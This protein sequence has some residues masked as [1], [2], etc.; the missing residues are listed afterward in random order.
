MSAAVG[1]NFMLIDVVGVDL[2]HIADLRK[3]S[4]AVKCLRVAD[5]F[6]SFKVVKRHAWY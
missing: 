6:V 5:Q 4:Q 2:A 1:T 3:E